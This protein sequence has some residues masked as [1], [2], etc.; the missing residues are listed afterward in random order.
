VKDEILPDGTIVQ[1]V[2][3]GE[4]QL[5]EVLMRRHAARVFRAAMSILRN[6]ADA[7]EVVQESFVRAYVHLRGLHDLDCFPGWISRIAVHQALR[8]A[9]RTERQ[10]PMDPC[11]LVAADTP[12]RNAMT[13][14]RAKQLREAVFRLPRQYR[15]V[16]VLRD[17]QEV[18]T[19][20]A[21]R[22]LRLTVANVKVRLHRAHLMLRRELHKRR[23][24]A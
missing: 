17:L 22:S 19:P 1:R 10:L 6:P 20:V 3:A 13:L 2:L 24:A 15:D 9:K 4:T 16:V 18:D 5:F 23:L 11:L 21:A 8:R 7:E 14:E 12:E